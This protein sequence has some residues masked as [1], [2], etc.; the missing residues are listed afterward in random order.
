MACVTTKGF[1]RDC[2]SNVGGIEELLILERS[3]MS[4]YTESGSE[5]TAIT[6]GGATWRQYHLKKE[7]GSVTST[8]TIDPTN[9]TRFS[10]SEIGFSINTFKAASVNELKVAL[11]GQLA[12]IAKDNNGRYWALGFQSWAE[13]TSLV[14]QTGTAYGDQN[15]FAIT[16]SAKEPQPPYEV[17]SSVIGGLTYD[18]A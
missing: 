1:C 5:V 4:A 3:N 11:L 16:I 14:T 15:G 6:D 17:A 12:I 9:G 2:S 7:V 18:C 8:M 13:G 10:E